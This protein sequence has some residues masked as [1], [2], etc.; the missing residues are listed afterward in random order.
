[1]SRGVQVEP[2]GA[3][4]T[5]HHRGKWGSHPGI[6]ANTD[7]RARRTQLVQEGFVKITE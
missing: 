3:T 4:A 2:R 6:K 1:M 5:A 7:A